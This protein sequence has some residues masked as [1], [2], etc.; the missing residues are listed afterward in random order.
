MKIAT[1]R[2]AIMELIALDANRPHCA[3][4]RQQLREWYQ[5]LSNS[6]MF[7]ESK[8]LMQTLAIVDE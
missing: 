7:K 3:V 2:T 4:V 6:Q 1:Q 8:R 5:F